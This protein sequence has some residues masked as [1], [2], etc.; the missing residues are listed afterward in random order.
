MPEKERQRTC[1]TDAAGVRHWTKPPANDTRAAPG[2]RM[3]RRDA[4]IAGVVILLIVLGV[5]IYGVSKTVTNVANTTASAPRTTGQGSP[6]ATGLQARLRDRASVSAE[7]LSCFVLVG[8]HRTHS[9]PGSV[10]EPSH[11]GDRSLART[12]RQC[13]A[14]EL[15]TPLHTKVPA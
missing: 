14:T 13:S 11:K 12:Q 9:A 3:E 15:G 2:S 1:L 8:D 5:V 10:S 4:I 7:R 6:A